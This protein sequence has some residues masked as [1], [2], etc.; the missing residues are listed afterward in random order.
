MSE[1]LT[2]TVIVRAAKAA[3]AHRFAH[4]VP[5]CLFA[6]WARENLRGTRVTGPQEMVTEAPAN[7]HSLSEAIEWWAGA[8]NKGVERSAIELALAHLEHIIAD[9]EDA[10]QD[11]GQEIIEVR[12]V[13][14]ALVKKES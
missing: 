9:R 11:P 5:A 4:R 6:E 10:Y 3:F 1:I 12:N 14:L 7:F 13:L 8:E 2:H